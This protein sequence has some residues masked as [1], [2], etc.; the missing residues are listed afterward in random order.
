VLLLVPCFWQTR[1]Q[2]GDL[3]SHIYNAWLAAEIQ[4]RTVEGLTLTTQWT[5]VLFDYW[6]VWLLKLC[7]AGVAQRIAV[8]AAVL[9]FAWGAFVLASRINGRRPWEL[10]PCI[11]VLAYGWVF[12]AGL[13]N[14]YVSLG[15]CLWALALLWSPRPLGWPAAC[16]LL[17]VAWLAH[18]LPVLWAGGAAVYLRV[19]ERFPARLR[20][21][22]LAA[23]AAAVCA[24]AWVLTHF[25]PHSWDSS[26]ALLILGVGQLW[27]YGP[28]YL[29]VSLS[30]L[31]VWT[32]FGAR[33][34]GECR[35]RDLFA[36]VP[37]HWLVLTALGI[38]LVPG[39]L[40]PPGYDHALKYIPERMSLA[41][42]VL[43]CAIL[44]ASR[45]PR[46]MKVAALA[47]AG[48]YFSFILKDTAELN[49]LEDRMEAAVAQLPPRQRVVSTVCRS[50]Y[51]LWWSIAHL[52]DRVCVGRCYS[53]GNYEPSTGQFRVRASK[54]NPVVVS[55]YDDSWEIWMGTYRV[56]ERD[57]PLFLVHPC[58]P[59]G[60]DF[61]LRELA[62]GE[63]AGVPCQSEVAG[64]SR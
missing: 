11:A 9:I 45:P 32:L 40:Q 39:W 33:L 20:F 34:L 30:L 16:L 1:I 64:E 53:Y 29:W 59:S 52:I 21:L 50:G 41:A 13:F 17:G 57:L 25:W 27:V 3:S 44:G 61:C 42:G 49:A 54:D 7:G 10:M 28:R 2:A 8:G 62:A 46:W 26:Q 14:F 35:G 5:N 18:A 60:H 63:V 4:K 37:L 23:G 12:H 15:L 58:G 22:L 56:R 38:L 51:R 55:N 43:V 36:G 24:V 47:V 48:I 31:L 6:L 19:A